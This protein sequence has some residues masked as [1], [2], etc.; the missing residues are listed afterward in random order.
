M[1]MHLEGFGRPFL[2]RRQDDDGKGKNLEICECNAEIRLMQ[3]VDHE[4]EGQDQSVLYT[5][6]PYSPTLRPII[7]SVS[8]RIARAHCVLVLPLGVSHRNMY[9]C[10]AVR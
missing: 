7:N 1:E 5:P 10:H 3:V 8:S 6:L 9:P 4:I 2:Q